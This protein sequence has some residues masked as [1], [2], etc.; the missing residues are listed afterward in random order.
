MEED[1]CKVDNIRSKYILKRIFALL[2]NKKFLYLIRYNKVMQEKTEINIE[3]YKKEGNR[4][5]IGGKNGYGQEYRLNTN[6]KLFEGEY[7]NEEKNGRGREYYENG[8]IKFDGVYFQ[9]KK[10]G[11][12]G[13]DKNGRV[14]L[15]IEING[16]GIE[17]YFNDN[18]KFEGEYFNGK[19]WNGNGYNP[20]GIKIYE[21]SYGKGYVKE[22][23]YEGELV[24]EGE[25]FNGERNGKGKEYFNGIFK[26]N[27]F[28]ITKKIL[29]Y[30]D[31]KLKFEGEY[32]NGQRNGRGREYYEE[33]RMQIEG[34]YLNGK[35]WN[36]KGY[37]KKGDEIFEIKNGKG[38][39][40]EYADNGQLEFE[41]ENL[42]GERNGKGKEYY[43]KDLYDVI[44]ERSI[45]NTNKINYFDIK[46]EGEYLNG[47]RNGKG[48]EYYNKGQIILISEYLNGKRI[49]KTKEFLNNELI[50]EGQFENETPTNSRSFPKRHG[51]GKDF[52]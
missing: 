16:R 11:G 41:G 22:F 32:L 37:N 2:T 15:I 47:L 35:R 6:I 10:V 7:I 12:V 24:F 14:V 26:N 20:L 8:L 13:Y 49:G 40:I 38:Y 52:L 42:N 30:K 29:E 23:N 43:S 36:V 34:E 5:K 18:I 21:L 39:I 19:K 9:G 45:N 51:K 1:I 33:G 25:Y 46:F 48:K 17:L 31:I 4:I 28:F 44:F 27:N 3:N 50:F